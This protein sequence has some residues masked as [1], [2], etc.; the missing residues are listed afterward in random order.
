M[1]TIGATD[2]QR[3]V[4]VLFVCLGN[5]CRSPMAEGVFRTLTKTDK[6]VGKVDSA[7]TGAYH[8]GCPPDPRTMSVLEENGDID[9]NHEARKVRSSD[10]KDFDFVL[11]MDDENLHDLLRLQIRLVRNSGAHAAP[12]KVM[13]FGDFGGKK[14][15]Q[16]VDPYYGARD[17]FTIAYEQMVRFS[18]GFIEQVLQDGDAEEVAGK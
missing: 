9:Y 18:S 7:G 1:A 15:E 10:F 11:A 14:G 17:G 5:I 6:R 3:P 2:V 8:E 16:V 13:L 4:S 12:A